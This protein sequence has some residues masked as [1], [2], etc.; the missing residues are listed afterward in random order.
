MEKIKEFLC[1]CVC[2]HGICKHGTVCR[3]E[4]YKKCVTPHILHTYYCA[5]RILRVSTCSHDIHTFLMCL[6]VVHSS[7]AIHHACSQLLKGLYN[8]LFMSDTVHRYPVM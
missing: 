7:I 2:K 3:C 8:F 6:C 5:Q 1:E 4:S